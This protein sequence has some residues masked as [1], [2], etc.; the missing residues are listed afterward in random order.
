MLFHDLGGEEGETSL[1]LGRSRG[2]INTKSFN[3][4]ETRH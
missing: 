3:V 1:L 2:E 4:A